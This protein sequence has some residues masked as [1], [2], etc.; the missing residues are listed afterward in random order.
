MPKT[1]LEDLDVHYVTN[2]WSALQIALGD[3]PWTRPAQEWSQQA[4]E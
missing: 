2:V 4:A 1:V 3:G